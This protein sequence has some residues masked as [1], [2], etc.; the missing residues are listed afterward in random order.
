MVCA[1]KTWR[2][3]GTGKVFLGALTLIYCLGFFFGGCGPRSTLYPESTLGTPEH[4]VFNGFKLLR[5]QRTDDA[6]FEFEQALKLDPRCSGAYVGIAWVE[7]GKGDF[8]AAFASMAH[9]KEIAEKNEEKAFVEV[10]FMGLYTMQKSADWVQRV[11]RS[12][13][14]ASSLV[15]DLPE[16]YFQLGVAYRQ[17]YRF[18]EAEK[19]FR[20]VLWIHGSL[21]AEAKEELDS[22]R[23]IPRTG[24]GSLAIPE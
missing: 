2:S 14:S 9:A 22:M 16:T 21:V 20:K 3:A 13:V 24:P 18:A 10:G 19:A 6:Q 1:V 15:E 8:S 23:D 5:M 12:F 11:E 7:G 17:A 4:H